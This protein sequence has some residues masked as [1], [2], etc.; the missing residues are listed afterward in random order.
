M[1]TATTK[2]KAAEFVRVAGSSRPATGGNKNLQSTR[3]NAVGG[4]PGA[5][6]APIKGPDKGNG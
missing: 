5:V 4:V 2:S 3:R 1:A 6:V